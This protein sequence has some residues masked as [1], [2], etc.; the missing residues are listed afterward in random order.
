MVT[1]TETTRTTERGFFDAADGVRIFF[2]TD[3]V[4]NPRATCVLVHGYLEHCGRYARVVDRLTAGG[5]SCFRFDCRGHGQS[6][7]AR[8]HVFRFGEYLDDLHAVFERARA[9]A[10]DRPVFLLGH[11]NGGLISLNFAARHPAGLAGVVLS[12][13]FF[14][15][16]SDVPPLKAFAGKLLSKLVPQMTLPTDLDPALVS[17][18]PQVVA[19]YRDDPMVSHRASA[20]WFTEAMKAHAD[21]PARAAEVRVPILVQQGGDDQ[22][23][24][25][26]AVRRVF[27]HVGS[28]DK[29]Y[30]EYEGLFHE[31]WFELENEPPLA[32]LE[33]WL[34][35]H[36]PG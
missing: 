3:T 1:K 21:A 17:H 8:G 16:G 36:L 11:S 9:A 20:R 22:V 32:D 13:P 35:A 10:E 4:A 24:S 33:A 12:S 31:I 6:G 18:D 7:G 30:E 23:A 2:E 15:F 27:E 29:R 34:R 5:F 26:Q 28:N 19:A 25:P 14:G